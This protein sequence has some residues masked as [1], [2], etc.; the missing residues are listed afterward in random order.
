MIR[1]L[2]MYNLSVRPIYFC[3][4]RDKKDKDELSI[5]KEEGTNERKK[6]NR[7]KFDKNAVCSSFPRV[8]LI[9]FLRVRSF[10]DTFRGVF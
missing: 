6:Q 9:I 5:Y 2:C 4:Q 10:F 8:F 7:D 3:V 1:K